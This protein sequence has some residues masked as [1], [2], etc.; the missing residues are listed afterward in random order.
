MLACAQLDSSTLM[1]VRMLSGLLGLPTLVNVRQTAYRHAHRPT[2]LRCSS[3]VILGWVKLTIKFKHDE[4]HSVRFPNLTGLLT[5]ISLLA[6]N[7]PHCVPEV[8]SALEVWFQVP[9]AKEI[10]L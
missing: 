4:P 10:I 7:I 9:F 5:W 2:S 6:V 8:E 3:L 1:Q